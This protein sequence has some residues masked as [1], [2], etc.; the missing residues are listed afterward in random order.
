MVL[1][2][3]AKKLQGVCEG[4]YQAL[5]TSESIGAALENQ[6]ERVHATSTILHRV[7]EEFPQHQGALRTLLQALAA[8]AQAM[9][10]EAP[11]EWREDREM[12]VST[13]EEVQ[14]LERK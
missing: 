6:M 4:T 12:T 8:R 2:N 14:R 11:W 9:R 5:S 10:Q 7:C 1:Q 13:G 3:R